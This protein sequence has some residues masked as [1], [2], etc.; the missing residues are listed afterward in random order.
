MKYFFDQHYL[1]GAKKFHNIFQAFEEQ[2]KTQAFPQYMLDDELVDAL[3]H[4]KRPKNLTPKYI[5]DLMVKR[6]KQ[7]RQDTGKLKLLFTGG[8][9]S[10]TILRLCMENSIYLDEVATHMVSIKQ[11]RKTNIEYLP[12][13]KYAMQ[14]QDKLIGKINL[15]HPTIQD[16]E[17]QVA[18]L[19]WFLDPDWQR[20]CDIH[21]RPFSYPRI[22]RDDLQM[23]EDTIVLTGYEKPKLL[24]ED[25]HAFWTHDDRGLAETSG[26]ENTIPFFLDKGNPELVCAMSYAFLESVNMDNF[27]NGMLVFSRIKERTLKEKIINNLGLYPTGR[28]YI[29]FH[30][31]GKDKYNNSIKSRRFLKEIVQSGKPHLVDRLWQ[32][33]E[34][35]YNRYKDLPHALE[36]KTSKMIQTVGRYAQKI[37]ILQD[38]FAS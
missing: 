38:K 5:K 7:I 32:T 29:D 27:K 11:C 18:S 19:E 3:K 13:I 9:D 10:N 2:K 12:G 8:T 26:I 37:P 16:M 35:I 1:C 28:H 23:D 21:L 34:I 20:G 30:L 14:Y 31:L 22:I 15:I 33:H 24:I 17:D 25:G 36:K 6:L 4:I